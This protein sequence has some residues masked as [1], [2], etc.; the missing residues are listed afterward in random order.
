[1]RA[2]LTARLNRIAETAGRYSVPGST[3]IDVGSDHGLLSVYCLRNDMFERAV[4]T[5]INQ[6]PADRSLAAIRENLL[7]DR[8]EVMVT[9]GLS[10]VPV[11]DN[12][13]IVIAGMGG[14][15]I[16]D[17]IGRFMEDHPE[18]PSGVRFILQP[19]KSVP[20]L[21]EWLSDKGFE[22]KDEDAVYEAGFYY[23][24]LV[25]E[26]IGTVTGLSDEEIYYGPRMLEKLDRYPDYRDF[27]ERVFEMRAR[28][29]TRLKKVLEERS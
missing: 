10:G 22:I 7:E 5:D 29:D 3:L 15:N 24:V 11:G 25:V 17:I 13:V 12:D 27:L 28:G 9:D 23:C 14:N 2:E 19:Q 26:Y 16:R 8:A 6:G 18:F 20:E 1:M 4:L 21:R